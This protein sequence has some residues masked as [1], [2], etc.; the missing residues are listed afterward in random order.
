MAGSPSAQDV[1]D[2]LAM[3]LERQDAS[4]APWC[5]PGDGVALRR[6][7]TDRS[8]SLGTGI[9]R[10]VR[11]ARL[12]A[13][14]DGRDYVR[15]L[16]ARLTALRARHFRSA[17][18][19][20]VADGRIQR[21]VAGLSDA[22]VR[23]REP[24]LTMQSGADDDG[25]EIDFAQMP[26]LAALLD[27]L[28]NALGFNVVAE[29]LAP[30]LRP[31]AAA[32]STVE[33]ARA[34]HAALNAWLGERLESAN[35]LLQAQRMRAFL[36]TRGRVAPEAIDDEGILL[37]WIAH[38]E[39]AEDERVDGFRLYR[40]AAGAMLR[41]RQALRDAFAA[42]HLEESLGRGLETPDELAI[43]A[44][45]I[46]IESWRS[47]LIALTSPPASRVK[48][49]TRKEQHW[50]FNYVGGPADEEEQEE[51]AE[52]SESDSWRGGL[53][54]E[55]R[56]DLAFWLTLLRADVFGAAQASTVARLRKR[57]PADA[58][59]AQA[60][61]QATEA[62]YLTAAAAYAD[63]GTQLHIESLAALTILMETGAAEAA[64]LLDH[65]GGQQALKAIV[66]SAAGSVASSGGEDDDGEEDDREED[67]ADALRR[68][69][70]PALKAALADPGSV[71]DDAGRKVLLE[72]LAAARKVSRAGFRREDRADAGMLAALQSGAPAV[73]EVVR[74]LDRLSAVLSHKAP[75]GD[76]AGDRDRF[77]AAFKRI[78]LSTTDT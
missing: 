69:I 50:L 34:L 40:S 28:H 45:M 61:E 78:Y 73:I 22:G 53:A 15:F 2:A 38:A 44:A 23:L 33:V 58:A 13:I 65:L 59:I 4:G 37:F 18:Q 36:A 68:K 74:E 52:E 19:G 29:L 62:A 24:A 27:F 41:Y 11:L 7:V 64:I 17:L 31:G 30:L 9:R 10:A 75:S 71:P 42:H 63:V 14:A 67:A 20:A 16:Y 1:A 5:P 49:L 66:G 54:G 6:W 32:N 60:M 25:F 76:I 70:A 77:L 47:P 8:A 43:D 39:S 26:R 55:E 57:M 48:W 46:G 72:A 56:F 35:H 51:P 12:M 3:T 21:H